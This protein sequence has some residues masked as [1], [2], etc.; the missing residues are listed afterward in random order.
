MPAYLD[1]VETEARVLIYTVTSSADAQKVVTVLLANILCLA[2]RLP[3]P[4]NLHLVETKES[5][6]TPHQRITFAPA[7]CHTL[8]KIAKIVSHCSMLIFLRFRKK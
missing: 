6:L 5:A 7:R 8:A 3:K 1:P 2:T 4:V